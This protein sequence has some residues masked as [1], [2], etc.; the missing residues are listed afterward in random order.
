MR[1]RA[2]DRTPAAVRA[3]PVNP[4]PDSNEPRPKKAGQPQDA[5]PPGPLEAAQ[6][7]MIALPAC[8][9]VGLL[10]HV[11]WPKPEALMPVPPFGFGVMSWN[12][13]SNAPNEGTPANDIAVRTFHATT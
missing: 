11:G 2:R 6:L 7:P 10:R 3:A 12:I 1:V 5:R 13:A 8:A 9:G 4:S